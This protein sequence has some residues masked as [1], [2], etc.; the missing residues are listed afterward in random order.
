MKNSYFIILTCII[1]LYIIVEVRRKKFN[2]K[3][4]FYWILTVV[5]MLV[6]AIWPHLIDYF[7]N[8]VGIDYPPSLLFVICVLFL[9][10]INF[11]NSRKITELN[12]KII[13]LEQN[14]TILK[15]R[16]SNDSKKR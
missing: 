16:V 9:L 13:E 12:M 8:L 14:M 15:G 6:L 1:G 11:R 7:A 4:S 5:F 2:I 10:F 3:E